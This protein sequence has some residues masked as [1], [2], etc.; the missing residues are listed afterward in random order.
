MFGTVF[1]IAR[2]SLTDGP[3][4]RTVVFLKGCPLH[5]NWCHNPESQNV[6]AEVLYNAEKCLSCGHC[7]PTC[8]QH[9]H[10]FQHTGHIY[11]RTNCRS[12]GACAKTCFSGALTLA[13]KIMNSE[14]VL[15]EVRK[16]GDYYGTDG[17][18]TLS[19]GEPLLQPDFA[20]ELLAQAGQESW[21]TA[22]ETCGFADWNVFEKLLPVTD[23]WLFDLK[24]ADSQRHRQLTG[25]NN[26][27]ILENLY[28]LAETGA[29][30]QLRCPLIPGKNDSDNDLEQIGRIALK[31]KNLTGIKPMPYHPFGLDKLRHLG[32][33]DQRLEKIPA[34]PELKR[35]RDFFQTLENELKIIRHREC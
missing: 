4:I 26:E 29:Q 33:T 19:G 23:L 1:D 17:G 14:Q 30:I 15:A 28:K 25:R 18:I 35:Y 10:V 20:Y 2:F 32:R 27:K 8:P 12:C 31:L 34:E 21:H 3:G 16:D 11:N 7:A 6:N 13:G 22:V 5:C 9:C 24:C